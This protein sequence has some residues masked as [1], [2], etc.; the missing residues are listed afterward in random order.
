MT[1]HAHECEQDSLRSQKTLRTLDLSY[2]KAGGKGASG[3]GRGLSQNQ[4]LRRLDLS[5]NALW[6]DAAA[7]IGSGLA[8]NAA[9]EELIL[10]RNN[11]G[12]YGDCSYGS[13][14][15]L[16]SVG[17]QRPR[18]DTQAP[19]SSGTVCGRTRL[20]CSLASAIR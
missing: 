20:C 14:I 18:I 17:S 4:A 11:V 6:G 8:V 5:D 7:S 16:R 2:N 1:A 3:F 19:R 10:D 9:L 13:G 12:D 15:G